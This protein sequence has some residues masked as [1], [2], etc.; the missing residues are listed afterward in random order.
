M[1]DRRSFNSK[2]DLT[3]KIS[4]SVFV[5]NF[6]DHFSSRDLWN[7]CTAYGNVENLDRLIGN[8]CTIWIG[9][10]R[11]HANPVRFQR[12]IRASTVQATKKNEGFVSNSFASVLKSGNQNTTMACD[13]TPAIVL[14]DSCFLEKN[15]SCFLMRR[16]KDINSLSNLY[17]ILANEGFEH[18]NL[19]YL[20][21]FWVLLDTGSTASKEKLCKHVGVA[22]WFNQLIPADD[23][24]VSEDRLWKLEKICLCHI[25]S[26]V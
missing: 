12:E 17:V 2:E 15:M 6:L 1:G 11:L 7:V 4:K 9:R 19:T 25:R 8:L 26:C 3:M 22:S 16:I 10:L 20:G 13:T 23:S 5:T 24:F 14:D 18:V 21:G